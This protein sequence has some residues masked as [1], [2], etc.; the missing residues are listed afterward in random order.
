MKKRNTIRLQSEENDVDKMLDKADLSE[1]IQKAK[2]MRLKAGRKPIGTKISIVLPVEL[3][4]VLRG[5][6][7]KRAIG[8][9]TLIRI[10]VSENV[11]KY[12]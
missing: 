3:I 10:I 6:A 8:Y 12:A 4:E 7:N 9:Q 1:V 2:P 11:K 5:A